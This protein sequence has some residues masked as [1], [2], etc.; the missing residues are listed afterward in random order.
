MTSSKIESKMKVNKV[1]Q[2]YKGVGQYPNEY[3]TPVL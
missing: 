2:L 3:W 1:N